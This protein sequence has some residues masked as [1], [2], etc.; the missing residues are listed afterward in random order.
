MGNFGPIVAQNYANL[1]L[2][3]YPKDFFQTLQHN[4]AQIS[5]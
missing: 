1:Y 2:R 3:I 5:K 4:G